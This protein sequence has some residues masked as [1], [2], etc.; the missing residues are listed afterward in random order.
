MGGTVEKHHNVMARD[1][2]QQQMSSAV[3]RYDIN[4]RFKNHFWKSLPDS[5]LPKDV[6]ERAAAMLCPLPVFHHYMHNAQ[7][8]A[9]NSY[10]R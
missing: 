6:Q 2:R 5:D 3:C 10:R 4:C 8:Q 7:C 9:K 1:F